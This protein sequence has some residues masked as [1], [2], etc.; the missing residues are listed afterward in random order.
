[1]TTPSETEGVPAGGAWSVDPSGVGPS[2]APPAGPTGTRL[3]PLTPLFSSLSLGRALLPQG[4]IAYGVGGFQLLVA[5]LVVQLISK[6]VAWSRFAYSFDGEVLRIDSGVLSRSQELIPARRIQQVNLVEK[7]YHRAVG[8]ATLRVETAGGGTGAAVALEVVAIDEAHRLRDALLAAKARAGA[9]P[10]A[11]G[12]TDDGDTDASPGWVPAPW[13]VVE[14]GYRQLAIAGITGGEL[15][16]IFASLA[17]LFTFV[18]GLPDALA[19]RLAGVE[20][21]LGPALVVVGVLAFIVV[22]LGSAAGAAILRHAGYH[23]VLLGDELHV[24]RGLLERK[25]GAVPL[26]RI[27]AVRIDASPARRLLGLVSMRFQSAG[28]G[29]AAEESRIDVPVLDGDDVE[30]V[31]ALALPGST[32]IPVLG[33][34]PRAALRRAVIRR[35]VPTLVLALPFVPGGAFPAVVALV[36]A[37]VLGVLWGVAAYRALGH[38]VGDGFLYTRSGAFVR[39]TVVVP[40]ARAQSAKVRRSPFQRRAGLGTLVVDLAGPGANPR[41]IDE[42]APV[43]TSVLRRLMSDVGGSSVPG[44]RR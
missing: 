33:R 21:E 26:A 11:E 15:L 8:V 10:A 20:V 19:R 31:L 29:S 42:A 17:S 22:W 5:L 12:V 34:P 13:T 16:V 1:V 39:R 18:D 27:Q 6:T 14:L 44:G 7:L 43:A 41:V 28:S 3:H 32:P 4:I 2:P 25:Q 38:A 35:V 23:L 30:R 37:L 40:T 36:G 9:G 24:E